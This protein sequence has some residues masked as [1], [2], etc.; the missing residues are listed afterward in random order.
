[1]EMISSH[2]FWE[3]EPPHINNNQWRC[4]KH[5]S[6][7]LYTHQAPGLERNWK[8]FFLFLN[9]NI[10]SGYSKE[11]SRWDGSFEHPKRMFK[12]ID[13]KIIATLRKLF[14]FNWPFDT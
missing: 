8:L 1:M 7:F 6:N 10:C 13:K 9:E 11:L 14:L 3:K 4:F 5:V 2:L 12:L